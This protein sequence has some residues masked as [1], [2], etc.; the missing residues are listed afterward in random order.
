MISK[1]IL[2]ASSFKKINY[3]HLLTFVQ[4]YLSLYEENIEQ[5]P[6]MN[7]IFYL[8]IFVGLLASD[9]AAQENNYAYL[10]HYTLDSMVGAGNSLHTENLDNS[11]YKGNVADNCHPSIERLG[12]R[13][14]HLIEIPGGTFNRKDNAITVS[15][16]D[17]YAYEVTVG[18]FKA[19]AEATGYKTDA[20]KA[21]GSYIWGGTDWILK[22]GI[23]WRHDELG[24]VRS[25]VKYNYPVI[26]VSWNDAIAYCDW[27]TVQTGQQFRLPTE[28]EWEY[29]AGGGSSRR[30]VYAGTD[31]VSNLVQYA[32]Y[33]DQSC[34]LIEE[35]KNRKDGYQYSAPVGS[36]KPN[37]LNLYDMSGNVI[38]W[39]NDR[40]GPKPSGSQIN[41]QGP[42]S[43]WYRVQRGGS[44]YCVPLYCRVNK[45]TGNL[46][47]NRGSLYGFRI[48]RTR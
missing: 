18:Q 15:T 32:N 45:N 14:E 4:H 1:N 9:L 28:A 36:L 3:Y 23:N 6:L 30:T 27:L 5:N 41:P 13:P 47:S 48:A 8:L 31:S 46:P 35:H 39:C 26:H 12:L 21:E 10:I 17:L 22:S 19:F 16:F 7:K 40:Y 25:E 37:Q 20:E 2:H 42:E 43:G 44:W 29:A 38:E 24:Q 33:C 34:L 11:D